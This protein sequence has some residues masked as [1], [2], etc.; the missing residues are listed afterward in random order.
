MFHFVKK[1]RKGKNKS[2]Q[3][4]HI[5]NVKKR[6]K[7]QMEERICVFVPYTKCTKMFHFVKKCRKGKN[8]SFQLIHIQNVKKR[9]KKQI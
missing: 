4:I 1:C 7:K 5:Q 9:G 2:F 8:K 3:L 6:G